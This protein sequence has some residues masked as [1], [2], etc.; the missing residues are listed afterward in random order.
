[1]QSMSLGKKDP[2]IREYVTPNKIIWTTSDASFENEELLLQDRESQVLI[3]PDEPVIIRNDGTRILLDFGTELHGGIQLA[4]WN[5]VKKGE[6][7]KQAKVRVRFGESVM[8]AMSDIGG[9]TNATN[10]HAIRDQ[11]VDVSFLG[12]N[13]IGNTG[14]RFVRLD[15]LEE[16]CWIQVNTIKAIFYHCDLPVKGSFHSSDPLLNQIW[17]TGAYTVY[18]NMQEYIW[19]GIK[20][21]RMHGM[22]W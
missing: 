3:T 19:D 5:C 21:D 17:D 1:M 4:I 11:I 22:D 15:L 8:E 6:L 13:E 9:A 10:D 14:F 20:R 2:R 18:L 12:M 16:D 7:V